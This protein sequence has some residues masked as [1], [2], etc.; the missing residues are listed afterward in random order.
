MI[1]GSTSSYR[2]FISASQQASIEEIATDWHVRMVSELASSTSE[3]SAPDEAAVHQYIQER[4]TIGSPESIADEIATLKESG[5]E[6]VIC[7]FKWGNID[8]ELAEKSMRLFADYV[9]PRF[10]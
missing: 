7:W 9:I 6:E 3:H 8:H 2:L 4:V 10:R 5:V 1:P